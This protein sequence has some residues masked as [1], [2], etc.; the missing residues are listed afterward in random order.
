MLI[1]FKVLFVSYKTRIFIDIIQ[2][3]IYLKSKVIK[4][5]LAINLKLKIIFTTCVCAF[6][7]VHF[8]NRITLHEILTLRIRQKYE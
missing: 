1:Q 3:Q 5:H 4:L 7:N 2:T 6:T 8:L